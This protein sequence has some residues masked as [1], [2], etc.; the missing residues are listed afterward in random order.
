MSQTNIAM[1]QH[2]RHCDLGRPPHTSAGQS[3]GEAQM[4]LNMIFYCESFLQHI[5]PSAPVPPAPML[6]Y[7]SCVTTAGC[8]VSSSRCPCVCCGAPLGVCQGRL[9]GMAWQVAVLD[10]CRSRCMAVSQGLVQASLALC[11]WDPLG[12]FLGQ[13]GLAHRSSCLSAPPSPGGPGR[14]GAP[15]RC[16]HQLS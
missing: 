2:P 12:A 16:N 10:L 3:K 5:L 11:C 4:G 14:R 1:Y 15:L 8:R 7:S 13:C 6:L 9:A